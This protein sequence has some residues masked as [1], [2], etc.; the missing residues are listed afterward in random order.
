MGV[1]KIRQVVLAAGGSDSLGPVGLASY[2]QAELVADTPPAADHLGSMVFCS[3]NATGGPMPCFSDG[4][5][6]RVVTTAAAPD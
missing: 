1:Q 5:I 6:W 3:D 4:T 2:T